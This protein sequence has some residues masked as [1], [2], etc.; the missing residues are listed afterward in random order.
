MCPRQPSPKLRVWIAH[1]VPFHPLQKAGIAGLLLR[2]RQ[3]GSSAIIA[4]PCYNE[5]TRLPV[6]QFKTFA[7]AEHTVR[8]LFVDD[9]SS[10]DTWSVLEG[11]CQE[12]PHRFAARRLPMNA[13]KAE[14]VRQG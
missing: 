6:H 3:M 7:S 9:G 11:V 4:I 1:A 12:A 5:A 8:F 2:S 10:D 13:G 14:A